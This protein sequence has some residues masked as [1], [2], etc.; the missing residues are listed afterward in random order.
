[1]INDRQ[2]D[3]MYTWSSIRVD[4]LDNFGMTHPFGKY[5][6]AMIRRLPAT[7]NGLV[8]GITVSLL[9]GFAP[10]VYLAVLACCCTMVVVHSVAKK[11]H[12][13]ASDAN[14]SQQSMWSFIQQMLPANFETPALATEPGSQGLAIGGVLLQDTQR[15]HLVFKEQRRLVT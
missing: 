4:R 13:L 3:A 6:I 5:N 1:M 14:R 8:H 7:S 10:T 11:Y 9:A 2:I 12:R 15:L